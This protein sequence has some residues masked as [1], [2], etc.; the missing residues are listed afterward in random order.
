MIN[1]ILKENKGMLLTYPI[2][3]FCKDEFI[4]KLRLY[5]VETYP[6]KCLFSISYSREFNNE[7]TYLVILTSFDEKGRKI[8]PRLSYKNK[9]YTPHYNHISFFYPSK[10]LIKLKI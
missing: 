5:I 4:E 3:K 6:D 9:Q 8:T 7:S 1:Q 10:E 2:N